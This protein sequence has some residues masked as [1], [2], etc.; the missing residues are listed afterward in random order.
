MR[1][2]HVLQKR[3][4]LPGGKQRRVGLGFGVGTEAMHKIEEIFYG[5][6]FSFLFPFFYFDRDPWGIGEQ[7]AQE[8]PGIK[9]EG[10]EGRKRANRDMESAA[11]RRLRAISGHL[12]AS[13]DRDK[14]SNL[15]T[16][17][18]AGE[19][20]LGTCPAPVS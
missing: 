3:R 16:N 9:R 6:F 2:C 4:L 13:G 15:S 18:T 20:V 10:K 5:L 11:Q 1:T 7:K 14:T 8:V 19:F 17:A 12:I